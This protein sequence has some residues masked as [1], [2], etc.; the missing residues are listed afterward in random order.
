M[1]I[2]MNATIEIQWE[3]S[4]CQGKRYIYELHCG[5]C[6]ALVTDADI[7]AQE[8]VKPGPAAVYP[9]LSCGHSLDSMEDVTG[10]PDCDGEGI[11]TRRAT[12]DELK[13]ALGMPF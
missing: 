13:Q 1:T 8:A 12:L 6:G 11:F 2:P 3:C 10:C 4:L 7:A 5:I 9:D